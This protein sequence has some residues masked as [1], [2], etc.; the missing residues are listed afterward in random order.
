MNGPNGAGASMAPRV[1][2]F[3]D[4]TDASLVWPGGE[5][6][7]AHLTVLTDAFSRMTLAFSLSKDAPKPKDLKNL[8]LRYLG[9]SDDE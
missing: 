1:E 5:I 8:L 6:S 3:S 9:S 4:Q 2:V 7:P